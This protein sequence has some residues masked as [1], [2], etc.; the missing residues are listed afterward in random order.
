MPTNANPGSVP[1]SQEWR[2]YW[3]LVIAGMFG[4]SVGT[5]PTATLGLFMQPLG[6]EFGWSRTEISIGLTIFALVSMPLAP[7]A[8]ILVDRFGARRVA[9]PG[10]LLSG[11]CFA[12]FGL[13][14]GPYYQWVLIWV[15]YTLASLLTRTLVWGSSISA[16]FSSGR[17]LALAVMLC[18]SAIATA[19]GPTVARLLIE[20]WGWRGGYVGLG[21]GW[22][23]L[24]LTL[25]MLFFHDVTGPVARARTA[26]ANEAPKE[27][28]GGLTLREAVRTTVMQRIALAMFLQALMGASIMVHIVPMLTADGLTAAEATTIAAVLGIA[29]IT[30]KLV[31]GGLI[32][33]IPGSLLPMIAY[34]G[35][36]VAYALLLQA[37]GSMAALA[38]AVF[39]L[40]YC[41][42]ASMQ[43]GTYLTTRYAGL[44]NFGAIFGIISSLMAAGAGVGPVIAGWIFD[45]TGGYSLLLTAGI[46]VAVVAALAVFRL[47]PYPVFAPVTPEAPLSEKPMP[48]I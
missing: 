45:T 19:L 6:D 29:S 22:A 18:G 17:G 2:R 47:G 23:G 33:R 35:P 8:G 13:M 15:A 37:Q 36:G 28:P 41:S 24:A 26:A 11:T 16:A 1:A 44:R 48:A 43:L 21:I 10:L 27:L 39:V 31:T 46:P 34:S 32:D 25:A 14:S 5:L 42:G 30:G 7:F 12:A 38:F 3:L 20:T 4:M 9:L 40:G